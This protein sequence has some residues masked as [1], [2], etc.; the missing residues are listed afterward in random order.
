[1]LVRIELPPSRLL[2]NDC[3]CAYIIIYLLFL[4]RSEVI[5]DVESFTDLLRSFALTMDGRRVMLIHMIPHTQHIPS[6]YVPLIIF[7]TVL[8]VT[9]NKPLMSR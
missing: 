1:M 6:S 7:A 8:H 2:L 3:T 5:L 9:S 4:F